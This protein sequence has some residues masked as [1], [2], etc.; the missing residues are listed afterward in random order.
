MV[1]AR[2]D[3]IKT[4]N[5]APTANL[6]M[7]SLNT[8]FGWAI[9]AEHC[10]G[11]DP[12]NRIRRLQQNKRKGRLLDDELIDI[13]TCLDAHADAAGSRND[14][15]GTPRLRLI[16]VY[17]RRQ[18]AGAACEGE[19]CGCEGKGESPAAG[20]YVLSPEHADKVV[21]GPE[22]NLRPWLRCTMQLEICEQC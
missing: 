8:F 4:E 2:R 10:S 12:T 22:S 18:L 6:A 3:E 16:A 7:A 1:K 9:E 21:A 14:R 17:G 13:L 15:K 19:R 20:G 5:G 11:N